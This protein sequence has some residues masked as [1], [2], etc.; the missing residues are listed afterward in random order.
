MALSDSQTGRRPFRRRLGPRPPANPEPP[1]L[2]QTTFPTCPAQYPGGP[3]QVLVGWRVARSRAGFFP[4]RAAFPSSGAGRRPHRYFRGLLKLHTRYGLQSCSP[5]IRRL[6]REAPP[7]PVSRLG[8]SPATKFNQPP[9]LGGPS[10]T[11]VLR[12]WGA[13]GS[14]TLSLRYL[15]SR[16]EIR[17]QCRGISATGLDPRPTSAQAPWQNGVAERWIGSCRREI[18]DHV[19]ALNEAHLRRDYVTYY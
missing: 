7:L 1:S 15:R 6:C 3:D 2:T 11:G 12:R 19:I 17:R 5:T 13:P 10:P 8:R 14:G 9:P 16:F 4:V 18:L